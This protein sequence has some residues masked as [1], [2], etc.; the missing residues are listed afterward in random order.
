ML[1]EFDAVAGRFALAIWLG[2]CF[3]ADAARGAV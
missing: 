3:L 1:F 2:G